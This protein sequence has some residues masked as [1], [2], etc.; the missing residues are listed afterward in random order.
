MPD[1][2]PSLRILRQIDEKV[3]RTEDLL[4]AIR[5]ALA[6]NATQFTALERKVDQLAAATA[7]ILRR[8]TEQ[9]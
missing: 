9:S 7:E 8:L 5:E 6:L 1:E 3:E 2:E 4:G